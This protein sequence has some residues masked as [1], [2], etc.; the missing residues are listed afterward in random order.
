MLAKPAINYIWASPFRSA[1]QLAGLL[2]IVFLT[3][4][5]LLAT[6]L[7]AIERQFGGLD[8]AYKAHRLLGTVGFLLILYHPF[9]LAVNALPS[10]KEASTYFI[11][12]DEFAYNLGITALY[13]YLVLLVVTMFLKL[14]YHIWKKTHIWMGAPFLL[15]VWHVAIIGSDVG[16]YLPLRIW[17]FSLCAI[18]TASF[19]YRRFL[20]GRFSPHAEFSI[21]HLEQKNDIVEVYLKPTAQNYFFLPGQFAF[22]AFHNAKI[23]TEKHPFSFSSA[24][25]EPLVRLSIKQSG[26]YTKKLSNLTVGDSATLYGPH[27]MFGR[28]SME[29][30]N[31][32]QLWIAG[33]I[34]VT[35]FLSLLRYYANQGKSPSIFF[36][37]ATRT[38]EDAPYLTEIQEYKEK[39]GDKLKFFHYSSADMGVITAEKIKRMNGGFANTRILL[40]GPQGM[41]ESLR[42]QFTADGVHPRSIYFEDFSFFS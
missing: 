22:V 34:G 32:P 7:T 6:R 18:G 5:Y 29:S 14:P 8:R 26:D 28:F 15:A 3:A 9:F 17:I 21:E 37:Y 12:G 30:P 13:A 16:R 1:G 33:G 42:E 20:Y 38:K 23:S 27:G 41:M 36:I 39:L 40:C 19:L 25:Q 2:G 24:P 35:P 31:Q 4:Q 11:F 10:L